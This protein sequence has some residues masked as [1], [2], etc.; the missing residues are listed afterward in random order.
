MDNGVYTP[1]V[2]QLNLGGRYKFTILGKNSTLRLQLQN[3]PGSYW[4]TNFYT[5]GYFQWPGPRTI[6][7]YLT[8][9]L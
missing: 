1:A 3:A 9:D 6:F 8:T 7:G 5:P 2:T 4:W